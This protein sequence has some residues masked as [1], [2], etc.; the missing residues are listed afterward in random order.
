MNIHNNKKL[1]KCKFSIVICTY[2]A[3]NYIDQCLNSIY[4]QKYN[5]YQIIIQDCESDDSTLKKVI[6]RKDGRLEIFREK[7]S[8]I[9]DGFNRAINKTSGEWIV[10]LGA[11]DTFYN[12]Y[13]LE[14]ISKI[15]D[16]H[17]NIDVL[18]GRS[19]I[20]NRIFI[21]K[22]DLRMLFGN[23]VNHQSIFYNSAIFK[24]LKYDNK[25]KY[26]ADYKLNLILL[27]GKFNIFKTEYL[28]ANYSTDGVSSQNKDI[29][30]YECCSIRNEVLGGALSV[31]ILMIIKVRRYIRR[32]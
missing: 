17:D 23:T 14:N 24:N 31:I 25:Y 27:L 13:V 19:F 18:Y 7:D 11:D 26:A 12:I 2:N 8:G 1:I 29:G 3:E 21:N 22:F 4:N 28:I 32:T 5:D 6:E 15:I 16:E 10:F 9:Y 20:E 30:F